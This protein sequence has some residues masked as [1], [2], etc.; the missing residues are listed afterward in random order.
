MIAII[1]CMLCLI[2]FSF[3]TKF[4][5]EAQGAATVV[6]CATSKELNRVGGHYFNNCSVCRPSEEATNPDTA[7]KLWQMSEQFVRQIAAN[8]DPVKN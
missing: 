1:T 7:A 4:L 3:A 8:Q 6:Y 2:L 5:F